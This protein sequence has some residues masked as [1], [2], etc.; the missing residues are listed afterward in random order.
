MLASAGTTSAGDANVKN[1][2]GSERPAEDRNGP[3]QQPLTTAPSASSVLE[4]FAQASQQQQ[5]NYL[6]CSTI[7]LTTS[8]YSVLLPGF[9]F[10]HF[11]DLGRSLKNPVFEAG[12]FRGES[13]FL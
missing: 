5:A 1:G 2:G 12:H 8:L 10:N 9:L 11:V 6:C 13:D 7:I 4:F 3:P